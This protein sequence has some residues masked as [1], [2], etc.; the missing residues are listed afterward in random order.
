M[1]NYVCCGSYYAELLS[2]LE[3]NYPG[4]KYQ[5]NYPHTTH[6]KVCWE[7]RQSAETLKLLMYQTI[8]WF[9]FRSTKMVLKQVFSIYL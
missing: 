3:T 2:S 1:Q 4:L 7:N 9:F 8:R 5:L 6:I